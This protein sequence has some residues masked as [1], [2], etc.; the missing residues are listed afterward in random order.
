MTN[1]KHVVVIDRDVS[2]ALRESWP[3]RLKPICSST[4]RD[5]TLQ[6]LLPA[7]AEKI[8]L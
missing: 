3:R 4:M 1:A 8:S 5:A 6:A 7:S 2:L